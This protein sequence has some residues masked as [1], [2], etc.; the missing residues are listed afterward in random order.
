MK[1]RW[2][3]GFG[4]P[5]T[6]R[7]FKLESDDMPKHQPIKIFA[8]VFAF[9]PLY[10]AVELN[11]TRLDKHSIVKRSKERGG[12][13]TQLTTLEKCTH[14]VTTNEYFKVPDSKLTDGRRLGLKIV[15]YKWLQDLLSGN[16]PADEDILWS[17]KACSIIS[18]RQDEDKLQRYKIHKDY[19]VHLELQNPAKNQDKFYDIQVIR[20]ANGG[21]YCLTRWGRIGGQLKDGSRGDGS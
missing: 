5:F 8:F 20:L 21:F 4:A 18:D 7:L 13:V 1:S 12:G 19:N 10:L 9:T 14:L 17:T 11:G 3:N 16:D 15:S 2:R 6:Q